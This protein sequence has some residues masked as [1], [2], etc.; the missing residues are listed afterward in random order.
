M[1]IQK[2]TFSSFKLSIGAISLL[3][4]T[5]LIFIIS[6]I[7]I[8][9]NTNIFM[10]DVL[11]HSITSLTSLIIIYLYLK[12][13]FQNKVDDTILRND[14]N[15]NIKKKDSNKIYNYLKENSKIDCIH[16]GVCLNRMRIYPF[17]YDEVII[18]IKFY[19]KEKEVVCTGKCSKYKRK[20]LIQKNILNYSNDMKIDNDFF[21]TTI[22]DVKYKFNI[23]EI[24][25]NEIKTTLKR[26]KMENKFKGR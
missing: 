5:S 2:H 20:N 13:N 1:I 7:S 3:G 11:V 24:D 14:R 21:R 15:F 17:M 22:I 26:I 6:D 12:H 19:C 8:K 9:T 25:N 18:P 4:L 23:K 10:I 16:N